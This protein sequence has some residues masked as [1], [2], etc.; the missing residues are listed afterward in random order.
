MAK[1]FAVAPSVASRIPVGFFG[2]E[3]LTVEL[4]VL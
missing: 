3:K 4:V 1:D 2:V